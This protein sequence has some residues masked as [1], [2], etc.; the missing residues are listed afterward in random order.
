MLVRRGEKRLERLPVRRDGNQIVVV[1]GL[2]ADIK[3]L[4]YADKDGVIYTGEAIAAGAEA[5]LTRTNETVAE[6]TPLHDKFGTT[7]SWR[8][9]AELMKTSNEYLN[10]GTYI[11]VLDDLPFVEQG[12]KETQSRK[13]HSVVYGISKD[14][15]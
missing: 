14:A 3:Q 7:S 13:M 10:P 1:N 6:K 5:R 12:L 9:L 2:K 8:N 15:P 11:A 4:K